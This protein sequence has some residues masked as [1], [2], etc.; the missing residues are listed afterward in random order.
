M[1]VD[2]VKIY[3]KA[4]DGGNGCSSFRREKYIPK[5]GPD[6]GDGGDGGSVIFIGDA[7]DNSLNKVRGRQHYRAERGEHGKGKDMHGKKG[8]SV[9]IPVPVGTVIKDAETG[10]ILAD[11]VKD[12]QKV[13]LLKGGK[14]GKGNARFATAENR[15]P[16]YAE[17]GEIVEE[18]RLKLEL[19]IIADVSLV[20]YPNAGK[21]TLISFVSEAK[22]KVADYKFTTLFP[23]VGIVRYSD[24][25]SFAMADIPGLID[26]AAE[27]KGLGIRF[28][29]H[30]ERTAVLLHMVDGAMPENSYLEDFLALRKEVAKF[31]ESLLKKHFIVALNKI[32]ALYS[33]EM[34]EELENYCNKNNIPYIEISAATGKNIDKLKKMLGETVEKLKPTLKITLD[35]EQ[36]ETP[37][38]DE[39]I[40]LMDEI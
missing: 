5:G 2:E 7:S 20:G 12:G 23:H 9:I 10:E 25:K 29:K 31:S 16:R 39:K 19:K 14:G 8:E 37:K 26:G 6:G 13:V 17:K 32:D 15:A 4:G 35:E 36:E 27:G 38:V 1:F 11:I 24:Y 40:S 28:L 3:V 22:P 30:I 21:S 33:E 34:R 18:K